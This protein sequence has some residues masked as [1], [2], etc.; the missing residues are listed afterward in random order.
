MRSGVQDGIALVGY[1]FAQVGIAAVACRNGGLGDAFGAAGRAV[2][3]DVKMGVVSYPRADFAQPAGIGLAVAEVLFDDGVD[4]DAVGFRKGGSGVQGVAVGGLPLTGGEG[5]SGG[6]HHRRR[7][8]FRVRLV[9][10]RHGVEPDVHIKAVAVAAVAEGH[11][12]AS[13]L[14]EVADEDG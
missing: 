12:P 1:P 5:A 14:A 4:E 8:D 13:R 6:I 11:F 2:Q 3:A 7:F 10:A 9:A